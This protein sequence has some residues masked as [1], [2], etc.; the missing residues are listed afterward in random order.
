MRI[1]GRFFTYWKTRFFQ[2]ERQHRTDKETGPSYPVP[3]RTHESPTICSSAHTVT[4]SPSTSATGRSS[5][6]R[7]CRSPDTRSSRSCS[8][9]VGSSVLPVDAC[10]R[11]I[12]ETA[13]SCGAT[14][15]R[16]WE[17][18]WSSYR[19]SA[20]TTPRWSSPCLSRSARTTTGTGLRT[21]PRPRRVD[22]STGLLQAVALRQILPLRLWILFSTPRGGI[23]RSV[24]GAMTNSRFADTIN[25]HVRNNMYSLIFF[26][27][28]EAT[29]SERSLGKSVGS[30]RM[31]SVRRFE[32]TET[33]LKEHQPWPSS[34]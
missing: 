21:R 23:S 8:R 18:E 27:C 13:P 2:Y 10:S 25:K 16:E 9:T 33:F 7:P 12:R 6:R 15:C 30:L 31:R 4:S 22:R 28:C 1:T 20:A 11:S 34:R 14:A 3:P 17:V 26:F 24:L 5:G 32:I 29:L 19:R